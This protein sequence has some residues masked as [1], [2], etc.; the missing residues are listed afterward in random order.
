MVEEQFQQ[1]RREFVRVKLDV[2][3]RFK[4]LTKTIAD[5]ELDKIY[6]GVTQNLSGGGL[7]LHGKLPK[8][9]WIPELLMQKMVIGIQMELPTEA[10][11]IKAL[12]RV[13]WIETIDENTNRCAIGLKFKEI[14][15]SDK[16][17]IFNFIIKTQL[18]S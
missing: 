7:L 15:L 4:F 14:T 16:D 1:E 5:P 12:T 6:E 10:E 8:L 18:P 17:K 13:T 9:E 2:P 3:V 11:P